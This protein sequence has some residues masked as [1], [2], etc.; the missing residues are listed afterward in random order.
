MSMALPVP[1]TRALPEARFIQVQGDQMEPTLTH[2]DFVAVVPVSD[3][4]RDSVYVV[5]DAFGTPIVQRCQWL[6][7]CGQEPGSVMIFGDRPGSVKALV[8]RE[9]FPGN[10][11]GH[12][13]RAREGNQP[14]PA[15]PD[16][17]LKQRP[18][19]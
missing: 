16:A 15:G 3:F 19:Q 18:S 8:T 4:L 7:A 12:R 11:P 10:G 6:P 17:A 13:C 2:R 1:T 14:G 5:A 9:Q